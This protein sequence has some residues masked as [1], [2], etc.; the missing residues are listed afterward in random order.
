M[1]NK[2]LAG[3]Q[4]L[5]KFSCKSCHPCNSGFDSRPR[6]RGFQPHQH[7]CVVPLSKN[8]NPS[9]V[10][11]QPRKTCPF[12]SER[13]LIGRKES[14]QMTCPCCLS[15]VFTV[16]SMTG[17]YLRVQNE[18]LIFLFLNQNIYCGYSKELSQWDGSFEQPKQILKLMGKKI[19]T[20]CWNFLFILT[21]MCGEIAS[22]GL[23]YIRCRF[24]G[25]PTTPRI[26]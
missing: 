7:Q 5:N 2:Q 15:D 20:I 14:N 21:C 25:P 16:H 3:V 11:V 18:N 17:L 12:I 22:Q 4:I 9:L 10:L 8:I 13:L 1:V 19:F 26:D 24:G 6:G 23:N